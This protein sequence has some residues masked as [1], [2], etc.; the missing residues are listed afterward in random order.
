MDKN[1]VGYLLNAL[2]PDDHAA[3]ESRLR[4]NP[5]EQD[6]LDRLKLAL[7]PLAADDENEAPSPYLV[8]NTIARIA[9]HHCRKLPPA[10]P[11][12]PPIH[13]LPQRR[14][15]RWADALIA[16]GILLCVLTLVPTLAFRLWRQYQVYACASNLHKFHDGLMRYADTHDRALPM[17]QPW[18]AQSVA[19]IFV[20]ILHDAGALDSDV[21][22]TCMPTSDQQALNRSVKNMEDLFAERPDEFWAVARKL[23]GCYAY[24]LGYFDGT[25]LKGLQQNDDGRSPVLADCPPIGTALFAGRNSSN[26]GGRG[27][28]VLFLDGSVAFCTHRNFGLDGDDIYLDR[29]HRQRAGVDR[30][31]TVLGTSGASPWPREEE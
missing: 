23:S 10:P 16:A 17:V 22:V 12:P 18:G 13:E 27:Q 8:V 21:R 15:W 20:P 25:N 9:E 1:L 7:A 28:N 30:T 11:A 31:D 19:G 2:D 26:H 14:G 4:D 24:T 5:E 29:Q 6:Q 3:V